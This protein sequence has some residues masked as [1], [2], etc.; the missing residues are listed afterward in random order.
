MLR[1]GWWA[2]SVGAVFA[3]SGQ[4]SNACIGCHSNIWETYRR[5]GMA[6]SFARAKSEGN[7]PSVFYH[8]ASD[9]YYQMVERDGGYFQ[10]Q[11]QIAPD[12]KQINLSEKKVDFV[13]GSGNHSRAF[14]HR[15]PENLLIE[16]PLAWYAEKGGYWAMNP[17]Y[18]RPDHQGFR[19]KI[20]YDCMFCH[21]AY[22]EIPAA[23]PRSTPV[24]SAVP[25][26][27]N[28]QRCHGGGEKHIALARGRARAE[29]IRN[30]IV[31]PSRL[32]AARQMEVC[33]QC[34]LETTSSPLPNS[35]VR[36]ERQPFSF[37][38]G[39]PLSEFIL[40]FDHA[41][42]TGRDDKFEITGSVYRLRK[43]Q[44]FLKSNGRMTCT[45]CHDPHQVSTAQNYVKICRQCHTATT[46]SH[47]H[48]DVCIGCHMPKRRTEDVV[49]AVMT[50]HYIQR[51]RPARDLRAE[52]P[53]RL[54][55]YRGE[56]VPYDPPVPLKA[57]DELY[58]AIAQVSESS[59]L[60]TGIAR[61]S[62]AIE[63]YRP[64]RAE[65]YLQL[66]DA[67]RNA[68]RFTDALPVYREALRREP[69]S[70][71]A[72]ERLALAHSDLKQYAQAEAILQRLPADAAIL[73]RL[74]TVYLGERKSADAMAAFEKAIQLDPDFAQ[75]H[76]SL[77]ATLFQA[78]DSA[79][80]EPA[81]QEAIRI[82]PNYSEARYNYALVLAKA[83]RMD[84]A[85]TQ[86]EA[87]LRIDSQNAD[88][89]GLLGSLL[90][91][92]GQPQHAIQHFREAVRLKPESGRANLD[93]GA[94][95]GDSGDTS[96]AQ[97]LRKAAQSPDAAIRDQALKILQRLRL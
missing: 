39:E 34:H 62:A 16:L 79:R 23:N 80:A 57:S 70:I 27:I 53:E 26:G 21:N 38:P 54:T 95:L 64:A 20:G 72:A 18:D 52:I 73:T 10:R 9:I 76:N 66:G 84:E 55:S 91:A 46:P 93:L 12:G 3:Q 36:Y 30:A 78:G 75:A 2:I 88:A 97:Y 43:S 83:R 81:L 65:Y 85:Q 11:Y 25:E 69:E 71:A 51:E 8:R 5:T 15:T 37:V 14:L 56:V 60:T 40:H 31:N 68:G 61:L 87:S 28:C 58:L 50:D 48:F 94:A 1:L 74:G 6:R 4:D 42:G 29:E 45:T 7:L 41:P 17:G 22:P 92:K 49:H 90:G 44:C 77:G 33:M 82:Q 63:K 13:L 35:I 59:N 32:T 19:R 24:F 67:L 96:A 86:L 47:A 89:H